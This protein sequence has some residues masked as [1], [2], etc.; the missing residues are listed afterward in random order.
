MHFVRCDVKGCGRTAPLNVEGPLPGA[1]LPVE[2]RAL[3]WC[4]EGVAAENPLAAMSD[5]VTAVAP[6]N[7]AKKYNDTM[8]SIQPYVPQRFCAATICGVCAK[9]LELV[10]QASDAMEIGT[11]PRDEAAQ[12][13]SWIDENETRLRAAGGVAVNILRRIGRAVLIAVV[14]G[15][16]CGGC[17]S[18]LYLGGW[19]ADSP[20]LWCRVCNSLINWKQST[21]SETVR[22]LAKANKRQ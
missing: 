5:L 20:P 10:E 21:I 19:R 16:V 18:I 13:R 11:P 12:M 3:H 14:G 4:E 2:W 8:R 6:H 17:G 15:G 9:R 22:R 1:G 7:V